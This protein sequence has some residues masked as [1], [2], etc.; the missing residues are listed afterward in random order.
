MDK[1]QREM[2]DAAILAASLIL[3]LAFTALLIS[4][5]V[6]RYSKSFPMRGS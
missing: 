5:L 1:E 2:D 6:A 4:L 3:A